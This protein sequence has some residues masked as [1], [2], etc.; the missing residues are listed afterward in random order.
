[1]LRHRQGALRR[2]PEATSMQY[3]YARA[4]ITQG[5]FIR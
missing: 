3:N 2:F 5:A 4:E 1:V